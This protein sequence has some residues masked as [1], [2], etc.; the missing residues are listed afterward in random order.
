MALSDD[1]VADPPVLAAIRACLE[2]LVTELGAR[3]GFLVDEKGTP[4]AAVGH[5]EFGF[6]HPLES[7]GDDDVVLKALVGE[8]SASDRTSPY[9][10]EPVGRR[11]LLALAWPESATR[12][13][14]HAVRRRLRQSAK[15]IKALL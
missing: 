3:A 8:T 7:L 2:R 9:L 13:T 4:F 11:A 1:V 12:A 6:P 14:E 15:E 5:V 10:V